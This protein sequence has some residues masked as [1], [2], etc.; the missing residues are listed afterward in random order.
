[1]NKKGPVTDATSFTEQRQEFERLYKAVLE[2]L[3]GPSAQVYS[4]HAFQSPFEVDVTARGRLVADSKFVTCVCACVRACACALNVQRALARAPSHVQWTRCYLGKASRSS[5]QHVAAS[6]NGNTTLMV[7]DA[8]RDDTEEQS[9]PSAAAQAI[10]IVRLAVTPR[11]L[12]RI[13]LKHCM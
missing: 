12:Q 4:V 9:C 10:D 2:T 3:V 6:C 8:D 5:C 11:V 1:M 13:R 7:N